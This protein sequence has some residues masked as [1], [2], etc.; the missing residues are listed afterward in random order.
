[1]AQ[2][3]AFPEIDAV[4][5]QRAGMAFLAG[6]RFSETFLDCAND[7][8]QSIDRGGRFLYV[9]KKWRETL[10]YDASEVAALTIFDVLDPACREQCAT[11]FRDIAAG[12]ILHSYEVVFVAKDGRKIPV[13]GRIS[14]DFRDGELFATRGIFRDISRR[15]EAEDLLRDQKLLTEKLIRYSAVPIFVLDPQHRVTDWNRAC[16]LLTGISATEMVGTSNHWQGF[17]TEKRPCLA[18][19]VIDPVSPNAHASLYTAAQNSELQEEGLHAEG[20]L[21]AVRGERRYLSSDAVPIYNRNRELVAVIQTLH[22]LTERK[23]MEEELLRLATIDTLTGIYNRGKV[24]DALRQEM[25]RAAR[26][27]SPLAILLFDL[28]EFKKVND[29]HGHSIGDLVLKAVATSVGKQL[30]KTDMLGRW[31]GEEFMVLCPGIMAEDAVA[32]AEKLRQQ[33]E[34]LPFGVTIS[35]GLAGYRPGD[36]LDA[37]INRADKALYEA[38]YAGRNRVRLTV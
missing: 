19:L 25:A 4:Q 27:E 18:D 31:G 7:L 28:D 12:K 8:I 10:G 22:D 38:K 16:E 3:E 21:D 2:E 35:C 30:R 17:Y 24:E 13:E 26:Y 11:L 32:I 20:W 23:K 36:T 6:S 1:M 29:T 5:G 15:K 37:L 34:G 14:T 9:N 33:I